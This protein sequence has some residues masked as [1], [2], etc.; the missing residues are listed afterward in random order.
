MATSTDR[1]VGREELTESAPAVGGTLVAVTALAVGAASF[2][3]GA[4]TGFGGRL[5]VYVL[6]GAGVFVG[7]LLAMRYLPQDGTA[8]LRRASVAGL[9]GFVGIG[10]GTEAVVYGLIVVAPARSLYVVAAVSIAGGLVYW[11]VR[12]WRSVDDLTRPW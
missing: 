7:A 4:T 1:I 8:V 6:S 3:G 5:P 11:S 9:L 2:I 12:N 10:L